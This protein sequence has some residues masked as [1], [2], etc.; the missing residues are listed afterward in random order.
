M[1][2]RSDLLLTESWNHIHHGG[3]EKSFLQLL[4]HA[5]NDREALEKAFVMTFY[6][7]DIS[8]GLGKRDLFYEMIVQWHE[9]FPLL[10][11]KILS[12]ALESY[13]PF[14]YGSFRDIFGLLNYLKHEIGARE[15]HPLLVCVLKYLYNCFR[16]ECTYFRV[17][18]KCDTPLVKWIPSEKSRGGWIYALLAHKYCHP[19]D[20]FGDFR[21]MDVSSQNKRSLR[22]VVSRLRGSMKL[23]SS[24]I[25]E[26]KID[27]V[28]LNQVCSPNHLLHYHQFFLESDQ[29]VC[30]R[31]FLM[32]YLLR[33]CDQKYVTH[34]KFQRIYDLPYVFSPISGKLVRRGIDFLET[35]KQRDREDTMVEG[36]LFETSTL[37]QLL[38]KSNMLSWIRKY[39]NHE[40]DV[41][42]A[43]DEH[44]TSQKSC[45]SIA[46]AMML[47]ETNQTFSFYYTNGFLIEKVEYMKGGTFIERL[48]LIVKNI[49]ERIVPMEQE[50]AV[51]LWSSIKSMNYS[52]TDTSILVFRGQCS[53]ESSKKFV[54]HGG[55]YK[56]DN[57]MYDAVLGHKRYDYVRKRYNN[58]LTFC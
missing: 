39:Q 12:I 55:E 53:M 27:K 13:E 22:K 24:L 17:H 56:T 31:Y 48:Q 2:T 34:Y 33:R 44:I 16:N 41:V 30:F 26:K 38:W 25:A 35:L 40:C 42:L 21:S 51:S 5:Q 18:K 28:H 46:I 10:S 15:D 20:K 32:K 9:V 54:G 58:I 43:L 45:M 52:K 19:R 8:H 4:K 14:P 1:K 7:R 6:C 36:I 47:S 57:H 11:K 49:G 37:L 23:P 3:C 50:T 29:N